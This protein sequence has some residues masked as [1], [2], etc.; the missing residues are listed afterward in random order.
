VRQ[1]PERSYVE[2]A[3]DRTSIDKFSDAELTAILRQRVEIVSVESD[4]QRPDDES[5]G[6]S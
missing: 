6:G 5:L 4:E 1:L 3:D 2:S